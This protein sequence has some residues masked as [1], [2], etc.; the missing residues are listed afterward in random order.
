VTVTSFAPSLISNRVRYRRETPGHVRA[1][2]RQQPNESLLRFLDLLEPS[3]FRCGHTSQGDLASG[4]PEARVRQ[5]HDFPGWIDFM[6]S[7]ID[8]SILAKKPVPDLLSAVF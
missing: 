6:K 7:A 5:V 3:R 4:D 1:R 2:Q 8:A